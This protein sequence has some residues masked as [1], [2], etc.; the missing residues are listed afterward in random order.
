ML[1]D[2]KMEYVTHDVETGEEVR[3]PTYVAIWNSDDDH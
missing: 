1:C 2:V 3:I